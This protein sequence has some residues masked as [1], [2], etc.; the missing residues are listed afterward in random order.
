MFIGGQGIVIIA[1]SLF[2]KG[3]SGAF[4]MYMSEA[5]EEQILPNVINTAR[6]IWAVS[7]IYLIL[8]TAGLALVG[9]LNGMRLTSAIFHGA[10]VFMAAFDTGGL[11][12]SRRIFFI[13]T[14]DFMR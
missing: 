2:M 5:R 6:F 14:A 9:V 10:C 8:G 12:R 7:I 1:I 3:A 4:K 11:L 13:I